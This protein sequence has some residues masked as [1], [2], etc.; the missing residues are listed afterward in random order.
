MTDP[1]AAATF[2][3]DVD[4]RCQHHQN[5][6]DDAAFAV[7]TNADRNSEQELHVS[8]PFFGFRFTLIDPAAAATSAAHPFKEQ[9][10]SPRQ[11]YQ[12]LLNDV[13]SV[14]SKQLA[15]LATLERP[16][17]WVLHHEDLYRHTI[18]TR[19]H[20]RNLDVETPLKLPGL[21]QGTIWA[22]SGPVPDFN[23]IT[24]WETKAKYLEE[25]IK[26]IKAGRVQPRFTAEDLKILES[27]EQKPGHF[28][29][30]DLARKRRHL[31]HD[32]HAI[33][34]TLFGLAARGRPGQWVLHNCNFHHPSIDTRPAMRAADEGTQTSFVIR[35]ATFDGSLRLL[36][37][38]VMATYELV[39][40]GKRP[41]PDLEDPAF[42]KAEAEALI[43]Q[44]IEVRKGRVKPCF[45]PAE[46]QTL[47]Q[48]E[49]VPDHAFAMF[50]ERAKS[51]PIVVETPELLEQRKLLF[52][53]QHAVVGKMVALWE[54]SLAGKWALHCFDDLYVSAY[55]TH[56]REVDTD[57]QGSDGQ[58]DTASYIIIDSDL[59][60]RFDTRFKAAPHD[61]LRTVAYWE[62]KKAELSK[63]YDD[64]MAGR[65][66]KHHFSAGERMR[67]RLLEQAIEQKL[68][69]RRH[70]V[71]EKHRC[72]GRRAHVM[73]AW[74][75]KLEMPDEPQR[76]ATPVSLKTASKRK[77]AAAD[78]DHSSPLFSKRR[79]G[80]GCGPAAPRT[81]IRRGRPKDASA[82]RPVDAPNT[83][84][85]H[86]LRRSARI[87]ARVAAQANST[88]DR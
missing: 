63:I 6:P 50:A 3:E 10:G 51:N 70:P 84:V 64:V 55:D 23:D 72:M 2:V 53:S 39:W 71:S 59:D 44:L 16:G 77:R 11:H 37:G 78:G 86:P 80:R 31:R 74:L 24:F 13:A 35:D 15:T 25:K 79:R 47:E 66:K 20:T 75:E 43:K 61:A 12:D 88:T 83:I 1:A 58:D 73:E 28:F 42:W 29:Y 45:T 38:L 17:L 40:A 34:V 68:N 4:Y 41:G 87:V 22:G 46:E 69:D 30:E 67:I 26:D 36:G 52:I 82:D 8:D 85:T 60:L 48:L 19:P 76:P 5:L 32:K 57:G 54:H 7:S 49:S 62:Q 27:L 21:T 18:D 14:V 9:T 33:F 65:L 81:L 56:F